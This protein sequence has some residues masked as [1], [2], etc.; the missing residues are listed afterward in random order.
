MYN[1]EQQKE[2]SMDIFKVHPWE[3]DK[4]FSMPELHEHEYFE[5][6]F[7]IDGQKTFI[8]QKDIYEVAKGSLVVTKPYSLHMFEGGPFKRVLVAVSPS[9]LNSHQL[10]FLTELADKTPICTFSPKIFSQITKLLS[11][12]TSE[13]KYYD[14]ERDKSNMFSFD[15]ILYLISKYK[16]AQNHNSEPKESDVMHPIVLKTVDYINKHYNQKILLS[17][18]C[19][20]FNISKTWLC[21]N[22][23]ESMHLSIANYQI[24]LRI[25][26]AKEK[27]STTSCSIETI[28]N[29][30]G[31]SSPKY[32][33][34][35]FK[36]MMNCSPLQYRKRS[37]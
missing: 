19:K 32:F 28:S 21:K 14:S 5:L 37:K 23:L 25:N 11:L 29:E 27:L 10:S 33:G 6:Y 31:F 24:L 4:P 30:L 13:N 7:L 16:I 15:Y 18:L 12:M 1:I 17:D 20:T 8:S 26:K 9:N 22:F 3:S 34:L 2:K 36:K 35:A